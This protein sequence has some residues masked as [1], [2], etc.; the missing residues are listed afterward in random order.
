[1]ASLVMWNL[2]T[3]D[4]FVEG[5]NRDIS[6]HF[7]VWGEEL[8]RLSIEQLKSAGGLLFGRVT[9]ELLANHWPTATGEV[10]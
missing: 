6:W 10:A 8:E 4:G 2:A 3:L 9:F 5:N 7:D 1:V